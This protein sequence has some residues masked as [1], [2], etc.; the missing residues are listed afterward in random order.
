MRRHISLT[1]L[2][3][4]LFFLSRTIAYAN[5][6]FFISGPA[7]IYPGHDWQYKLM[8]H[9]D[10]RTLTAAQAVV[11]FD[12]N[13]VKTVS[14]VNLSSKCSFFAPADP[15]LG[16]GNESTPYFYQGNKLV[17]AC[18][19]S[20]PGLKTTTSGDL[21]LNFN[22][23]ARSDLTMPAQSVMTITNTTFRYIGETV[24]S[25]LSKNFSYAV[26]EST[27]S[28]YTDHDPKPKPETVDTLKEGEL[29]FVNIAEGTAEGQANQTTTTNPFDG[30]LSDQYIVGQMDNSIPPPP[31]DLPK[32][33]PVNPR[34]ALQNLRDPDDPGEV[35]SIQSLRELLIPGKSSADKSV[36]FI[37]LISTLTF[38]AILTILIWRLLMISR[39]NKIKQQH[40]REMI[41]GE[42]SVLEGKLGGTER[43]DEA[44]FNK[45]VEKLRKDLELK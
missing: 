34:Q 28:A 21:I 37:N 5:P 31:V 10:N 11:E 19:F 24:P 25:G 14:I 32:R 45:S 17:V 9:T 41:T 20:N 36:V 40:M 2:S 38:I 3:L 29:Q 43:I 39:M 1:L 12:T 8:L 35:L 42:L 4:S 7:G 18:G 23:T 33:L 16:F 26:Y 13:L 30:A 6:Y 27:A 22:L 44:E 15:S